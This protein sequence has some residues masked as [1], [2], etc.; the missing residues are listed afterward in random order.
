MTLLQ[1]CPGPPA[2]KVAWDDLWPAHPWLRALDRCP[3]DQHFHAEGDVGIH[4]RM[5]CEALVGSDDFR[6]ST[7]DDRAATF[8][9]VLLHDIGKPHCTRIEGDRITSRGH[10]Q[11]GE[12]MARAILWRMGMPFALRE[13]VCGL[14]RYHQTPFFLVDQDGSQKL[15]FRVT[16]VARGD[17]LAMVARADA[18]GR[19]CQ[20]PMDQQRLLDNVSLFYEYCREHACL[21]RPRAFPSAHARFVY[22]R[23]P[24]RDPLYAAH[25]D[26]RCD[27]TLMS[28]L[29]GAGKSTW[30]KEHAADL[31]VVSLDGLRDELGVDAASHQGPVIAAARERA[32][33][34]LRAGRSFAWDGTNVSRQ[35]RQQL[36]DLFASYKARVRIVY[37]E[38]SEAVLRTRNR[39]R[40]RPVPDRVIANLVDKWTVPD[41]TE[42]HAI[43]IVH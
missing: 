2:W 31:P 15:A 16:Q 38:E 19:R 21:D 18:N 22:F 43:H 8:L 5:A 20:D 11:R 13:Q 33:E 28:G 29:P 1:H 10:S 35:I 34:H 41:L 4:T 42:A 27:V 30:L 36:I 17:L 23:K 25:D 7:P 24:D 12:V 37:V 39:A 40:E 6:A 26:S 32:R 9:A 14:V 3:Q